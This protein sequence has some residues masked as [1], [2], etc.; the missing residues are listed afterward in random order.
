MYPSVSPLPLPDVCLTSKS[1]LM[2]NN[3]LLASNMLNVVRSMFSTHADSKISVGY[4]FLTT[5]R[6]F[7]AG[8]ILFRSV[9]IEYSSLFSILFPCFAYLRRLRP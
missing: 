1:S 4:A 5:M 8:F 6:R 3:D 2:G 9:L 7:P